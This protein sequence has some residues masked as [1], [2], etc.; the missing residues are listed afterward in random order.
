MG[1]CGDI[2]KLT[3][4]SGYKALTALSNLQKNGE[5][6]SGPGRGLDLIHNPHRMEKNKKVRKTLQPL[7]GFK[8]T[9]LRFQVLHLTTRLKLQSAITP[10][11]FAGLTFC[12]K[13]IR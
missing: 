8:P 1:V 5:G 2:F 7:A 3:I 9:T 6:Q 13:L 11:N 12:Y 10:V 4:L